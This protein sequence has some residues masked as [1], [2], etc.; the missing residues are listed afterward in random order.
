[1]P[2]LT[3]REGNI[4]AVAL[5]LQVV[6]ISMFMYVMS[7][8]SK[9]MDKSYMNGYRDGILLTANS[10]RKSDGLPPFKD[11]KEFEDSVSG[12]KTEQEQQPKEEPGMIQDRN[13]FSKP[14]V[15]SRG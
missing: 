5:I 1:M 15:M 12:S 10:I 11:W 7:D 3:K 4:I 9:A 2:N 14:Y 8:M 6:I 13:K